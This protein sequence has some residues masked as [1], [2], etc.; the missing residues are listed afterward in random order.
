VWASMGF[1]LWAAFAGIYTYQAHLADEQGVPN[2]SWRSLFLVFCWGEALTFFI[3]ELM[4]RMGV[5]WWP[6]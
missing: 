4:L 5:L 2:Q 1:A 3:S 6:A